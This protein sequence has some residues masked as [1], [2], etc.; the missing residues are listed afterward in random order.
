MDRALTGQ[1]VP[2]DRAMLTVPN[3]LSR[4]AAGR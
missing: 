4:A 1:D 2:T 3:V